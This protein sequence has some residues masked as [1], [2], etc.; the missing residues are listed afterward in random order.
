MGRRVTE[1]AFLLTHI[2]LL[3]QRK[4]EQKKKRECRMYDTIRCYTFHI[5]GQSSVYHTHNMLWS[6]LPLMFD[7]PLRGVCCAVLCCS[8]PCISRGYKIR[9][10]GLGRRWV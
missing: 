4:R 7:P 1:T 9:S 3:P 2:Y 6:L 5:V 8:A 10:T